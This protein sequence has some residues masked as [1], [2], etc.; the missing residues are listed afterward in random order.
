MSYGLLSREE[1]LFNYIQANRGAKHNGIRLDKLDSGISY[2][3]GLPLRGVNLSKNK[4]G[5]N[6]SSGADNNVNAYTTFLYFTGLIK[7]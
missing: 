4:I 2:G 3:Y 6:I 5:I 7:V 1:Q